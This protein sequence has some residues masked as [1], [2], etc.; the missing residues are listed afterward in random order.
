MGKAKNFTE[1]IVWQKAHKFVLEVYEITSKFPKSET[2]GL[3]SQFRRAAISIASNI[4][5]GFAK[6]GIA[7]KLRYYNIAEG[8]I[9][10]CKYYIILSRDLNYFHNEEVAELLEEVSKLL[11]SYMKVIKNSLKT[12]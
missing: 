11:G 10:E 8:S 12:S 9:Q 3:T 4:S 7:D 6:K 5:E 1:L 2:Y